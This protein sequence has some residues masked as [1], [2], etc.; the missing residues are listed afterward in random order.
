[1]EFRLNSTLLTSSIVSNTLSRHLRQQ[2]Q[3]FLLQLQQVLAHFEV[4]MKEGR[5]RVELHQFDS[6]VQHSRYV[7]DPIE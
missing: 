3:P 4:A 5:H 6:N 1:M 7:Q 2:K